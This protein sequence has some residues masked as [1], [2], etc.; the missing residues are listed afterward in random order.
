MKIGSKTRSGVTPGGV[1]H[2]P[3]AKVRGED[4]ARLGTGGGKQIEA[5][6]PVGVGAKRLWSA[7]SFGLGVHLEGQRVKGVPLCGGSCGSAATTRG[8]SRAQGR[9]LPS[10]PTFPRKGEGVKAAHRPHV[11]GV[12]LTSSTPLRGGFLTSSTPCGEGCLTSSSP[13]AGED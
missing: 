7:S 6:R 3:V 5:A 11:E 8:T 12:V 4:L 1:V 13:L 9:S 10:I 2:D